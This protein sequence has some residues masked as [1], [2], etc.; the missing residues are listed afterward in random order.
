M[1][2]RRPRGLRRSAT[3]A[4][5]QVRSRSLRRPR[6]TRRSSSSSVLTP[7]PKV[8][9]RSV[10]GRP[11]NGAVIFGRD[12]KDERPTA[13]TTLPTPSVPELAVGELGHL[14]AF[15]NEHKLLARARRGYEAV[16]ADGGVPDDLKLQALTNLGNS[17]DMWD[18]ISTAS[19]PGSGHWPSTPS[20]RWLVATSVSHWP[21]LRRSWAN[22]RRQSRTTRRSLSTRR[23]PSQTSSSLT[24]GR[25]RSR[26]S[27]KYAS[28]YLRRREWRRQQ[29]A[30]VTLTLSGAVST[31]SSEPSRF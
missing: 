8:A 10:I 25:K 15:E 14:R 23:S 16:A 17:Y 18:E 29:S 12:S 5:R 13:A 26:T 24:A 22:T 21:E 27:S 19:P 31:S 11:L 30:L 20:S 6:A 7:T 1:Q 28:G 9:G 4:M 2:P 3:A